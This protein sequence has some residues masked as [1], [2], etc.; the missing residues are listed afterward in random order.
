MPRV[1]DPVLVEQINAAPEP[2]R[3][4]IHHIETDT[5]PAG[6]LRALWDATLTQRAL[7]VLLQEAWAQI[8]ELGGTVD[9]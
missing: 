6:T 8:E 7:I 4:Y 5:D 2:L 1:N 9:R 3:S